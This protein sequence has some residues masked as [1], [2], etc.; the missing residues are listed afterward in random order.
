MF[1]EDFTSV[2][3]AA[4]APAASAFVAAAGAPL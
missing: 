3:P 4:F 1:W 2:T